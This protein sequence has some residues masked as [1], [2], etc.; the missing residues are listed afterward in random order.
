MKH[1]PE[2]WALK[3][4]HTKDQITHWGING[5]S[6]DG[7]TLASGRIADIPRFVP[8]HDCHTQ[9]ANVQRIVDCVNACSGINPAAVPELLAA[10]KRALVA[11]ESLPPRVNEDRYEPLMALSAA[12]ALATNPTL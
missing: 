12:I 1:T 9:E 6:R 4:I 3:A 5:V 11:I 8:N 2:P 10:C 7:E